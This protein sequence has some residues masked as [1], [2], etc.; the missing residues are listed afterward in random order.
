MDHFT[1]R[2]QTQTHTD[3]NANSAQPY[4]QI[5]SV[6]RNTFGGTTSVH[7]RGGRKRGRRKNRLLGLENK[8]VNERGRESE[9]L[10]QTANECK[11]N[12]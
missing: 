11:L 7:W 12:K 4:G 9:V 2:A 5:M 1:Q 6:I 8:N 10:S 3:T